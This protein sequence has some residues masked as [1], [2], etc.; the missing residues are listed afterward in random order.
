MAEQRSD[1]VPS[2]KRQ[3]FA[4]AYVGA[5][6]YRSKFKNEWSRMYP[7]KGAKNDQ[8]SFYCIP[9]MKNIKCDHQGIT[10]VKNHCSTATHKRYEK[11]AKSQPSVSHLL[12]SQEPKDSVTRAEVIIT[13]FL[14]QHNLP[15]ATSDH[16]G[17]LFRS[18]FPD[19]D[20][21][22]QYS[23][24][25]T[26]T[27]AIVNK[28]MGSHCHQ[29]VVQHCLQHP[30]SLGIDGSSDSDV[31]KMNT[32]TVRIF[33]MNRSKTV[34]T[35]FYNMCVTSGENASKAD[36]LFKVVQTKMAE[37]KIPWTQAVSLSVDN[38][39]SMIGAHDSFASRCKAQNPNIYVHGCPCHILL[40]AMPM[41]PSQ[42]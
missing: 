11:Q 4:H 6:R 1:S 14:V 7:V 35:H 29:Y 32:M 37:D 26:K 42:R 31:E 21:A 36:T 10:D 34:A 18:A 39:N 19:S 12:K 8:Y 9:C 20:I 2:P 25:R 23:C 24:G 13:N 30:F 28:A 5:A 22:K 3:K 41:M 17:P 15:L 27:C 40:L 33:D 16:L 38:T